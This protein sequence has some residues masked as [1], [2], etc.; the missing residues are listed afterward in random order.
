VLE[1]G[2]NFA[3]SQSDLVSYLIFGQPNFEVGAANQNYVQLVLQSITPLANLGVR[4]FAQRFLGSTVADMLQFQTALNSSAINSNEGFSTAELFSRSR[5]GA[6]YRV[7]NT[8]VFVSVS[9]P[10]WCGD[11]GGNADQS[12]YTQL[13]AKIDWRFSRD[14]S[15]QAGRE[16][17]ALVCGRNYNGRVVATPAQWGLSLFKSWRF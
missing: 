13:S 4:R 2:E 17:S 15:I 3:I 1:S 9:T 12:Y 8:N 10:L 11:N 5:I 16:P 7:A 6:D 14:A